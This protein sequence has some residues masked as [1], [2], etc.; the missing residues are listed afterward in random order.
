M[1]KKIIEHYNCQ[2]SYFKSH[3]ERFYHVV[4]ITGTQALCRCSRIFNKG[5]TRK[6]HVLEMSHKKVSDSVSHSLGC[7][8]FSCCIYLG[9]NKPFWN[10]WCDNTIACVIT[11]TTVMNMLILRVGWVSKLSAGLKC[12]C[13]SFLPKQEF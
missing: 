2:I 13:T 11:N 8:L 6:I 12:C 1:L 7:L 4:N 5:S 9:W 10:T 3:C